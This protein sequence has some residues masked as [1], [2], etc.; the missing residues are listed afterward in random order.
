M[1]SVKSADINRLIEE[2]VGGE[3]PRESHPAKLFS[4]LLECWALGEDRECRNRVLNDVLLKNGMVINQLVELNH[5]KNKFLGTVAHDLRNPLISIRGLSEIILTEAVG[6]LTEEQREYINIINTASSGMLK[7]VNDL[8]DISVIESGRFE[9]QLKSGSLGK[10]ISERIRVH[11][12]IAEEKNIT[13]H[14]DLMELPDISFDPD[15]I[16]RVLD[17]LLSNAIK[18][19]P[20]GTDIHVSLKRE[21]GMARV[22]VTDEGPGI[23]M[24]DRC[25]IFEEFEKSKTLPTGGEKSTGLGLAIARKIIEAH[26]GNV[27][28]ESQVELGST[29]HFTLPMGN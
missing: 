23:P 20:S 19:S 8:L 2:Y 9:L 24:E 26:G 4:A 6:P 5:L 18:F 12:V 11:R 1:R 29:F 21:K 27:H 14:Q 13:L 16:A 15:R 28:V 7:L 25:T 17:N 10:L 3:Y 22:S